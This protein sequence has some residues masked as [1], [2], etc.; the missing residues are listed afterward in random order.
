MT[1]FAARVNA[2]KVVVVK[3]AMSVFI[4]MGT[5]LVAATQNWTDDYVST[6]RWYNWSALIIAALVNG[7]TTINAFIDKTFHTEGMKIAFDEQVRVE[8]VKA[9]HKIEVIKQDVVDAKA[10][11]KEEKDKIV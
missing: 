10:D 9:D 7:C 8:Q 5:L 2:W 4:S 3:C 11:A 1:D 6:L